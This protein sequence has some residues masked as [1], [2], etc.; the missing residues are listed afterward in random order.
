RDTLVAGGIRLFGFQL[1]RIISGSLGPSILSFGP[2]GVINF[3]PEIFPNLENFF[4]LSRQT[5]GVA[6]A[7]N[8]EGDPWREYELSDK[9]LQELQYL[10]VQLYK[11]IAQYY[12][13]RLK[14]PARDFSLDLADSARKDVPLAAVIYPTRLPGCAAGT[15]PAVSP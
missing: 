8:T 11:A 1:G 3:P 7:E 13:L 9:R 2:S 4:T 6:V 12:R 10:G 15:K 14:L 5:G